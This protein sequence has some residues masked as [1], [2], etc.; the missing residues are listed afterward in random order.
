MR[1]EARTTF[2]TPLGTCAIAWSGT[3]VTRFEL[4]EA[5]ANPD[6]LANPPE[7]VTQII[8][9][10]REH[11]SGAYQDFATLPYDFQRVPAFAADVYRATLGV[12]AGRTATYGEIARQ[13]GQPPA[14]S[15]AVGAA[16]GANPWPLLVPCH[17][18]VAADGKMTG[19]SGPGGIRTKLKL[20]ALEGSELFAE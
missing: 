18:I 2:S 5:A 1:R 12:R 17:R 3:M 13:I 20:L 15:R 10:V 9:R 7:F 4:P 19:F 14:A 16:L 6:D 8:T 11:L